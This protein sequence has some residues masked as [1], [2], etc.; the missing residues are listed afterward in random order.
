LWTGCDGWVASGIVHTYKTNIAY[1]SR[2]A[3]IQSIE[4]FDA[5]NVDAVGHHMFIALLPNSIPLFRHNYSSM[6]AWLKIRLLLLFAACF[7][8][9]L[10]STIVPNN[11]LLFATN[12][13]A[14]K[15]I[16]EELTNGLTRAHHLRLKTYIVLLRI[17]IVRV[18]RRRIGL[19]S[20]T[21]HVTDLSIWTTPH[22]TT[23]A[24]PPGDVSQR[25]SERRQVGPFD[26][27]EIVLRVPKATIPKIYCK[28]VRASCTPVLMYC[29]GIERLCG[30]GRECTGGQSQR[31]HRQQFHHLDFLFHQGKNPCFHGV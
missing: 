30:L 26:K 15:Q 17:F 27:E 29:G 12:I 8:C 2:I 7:S 4:S 6:L 9:L 18:G 16:E 23:V 11:C 24:Y 5:R 10:Y 22:P 13:V 25:S 19:G 21:V 31:K 28:R 14:N 20:L 3:R 1:L